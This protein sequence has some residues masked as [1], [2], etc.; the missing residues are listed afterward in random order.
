MLYLTLSVF[1][2]A[3]WPLA[4]YQSTCVLMFPLCFPSPSFS[5]KEPLPS[6]TLLLTEGWLHG[7]RAVNIKAGAEYQDHFFV[8][9]NFKDCFC[10]I[11]SQSV[12]DCRHDYVL[13]IISI[14]INFFIHLSGFKACKRLTALE[15]SSVDTHIQTSLSPQGMRMQL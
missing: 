4:S 6:A 9:Q 11:A 14:I 15:T 12:E 1:T 5:G 13:V 2:L 3:Q 8:Q 10:K 7:N